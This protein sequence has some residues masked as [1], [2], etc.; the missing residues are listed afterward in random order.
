M[1]KRSVLYVH[2]DGALSGSTISLGYVLENLDR[3]R[4][5]PR[6]LLAQ[7]G[8]SRKF[9]EA[10][11]LQVDVLPIR[12]FPTAPGYRLA[13]S[14]H[15]KSWLCFLPNR[16]LERFFRSHNPDIVHI[17][18]K[19][20]LAA[21]IAARRCGLPVVWHARSTYRTTYSRLNA[22]VSGRVIRR[23]ADRIIAISEDEID[24]F[25]GLEGLDVIFNSI[26]L[27]RT[28]QAQQDAETTRAELGLGDA[29]VV[30]TVSNGISEQRGTFD[31]IRAAGELKKKRPETDFRFMVVAP[32]PADYAETNPVRRASE[33]N[34]K[35]AKEISR[36]A[37]VADDILFTGFRQD[38]LSVMATMD[39]VLVCNRLGIL[40]RMPFEAMALGR[41]VVVTAG[42]S[43]KSRVVV[44]GET[45][46]L[47]KPEDAESL[48]AAAC[49]L[50]EDAALAQRI[51][52][53]GQ[54]YARTHFN[55]AIN[56]R[57]IEAVYDKI[58][59]DGI[60]PKARPGSR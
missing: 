4:F 32:I 55:A 57:Q 31:F 37:G 10:L 13:S 42:H 5:S 49:R 34:F 17:N 16:A 2:H 27:D 52:L 21:G 33:H 9:F 47:A 30:G 26:D 18:D 58:I 40:G 25:E 38:V 15:W 23:I 41:P 51:S 53:A 1:S 35:L 60:L 24:G 11:G 45:A 44:D 14:G 59:K 22:W 3:E 7:D 39:I 29:I 6:L 54:A 50:L 36:D 43:G 56:T 19:T 20:L 48:A 12:G 28:I 46:L 8:P